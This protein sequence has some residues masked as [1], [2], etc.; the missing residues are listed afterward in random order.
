MADSPS[1]SSSSSPGT[2][3]DRGGASSASGGPAA[4]DRGTSADRAKPPVRRLVQL[5]LRPMLLIAALA[6]LFFARLVLHPSWVLYTDYSDLLTYQVP[7]MRFLVSSWQQTGEQPLWCPYSFA[8]MPFVHDLQVGAFYPFHLMLYRLPE[9]LIGPA[10]SW[11][12]VLHVMIA[13]WTM[14]A[15]ARSQGLNQTCAMIAA[16]GFMFSGKWLLHLVQ[17]AQYVVIGLAW[18]PLVLLLLERSLRGGGLRSATWAGAALA[19]VVLSSHPQITFY[20]GLLIAFWTLPLALEQAGLL[21]P[22][23]GRGPSSP[24]AVARWLLSVGWC[25]LVALALAAVQLLPTIEAGT[26]TTRSAVGMPAD[27]L[28]V[29]LFNIFG[30]VGPAP[31]SLPI[32]GWENRTGLTVIW[33]ATALLTPN[34]YSWAGPPAAP[35][36]GLAWPDRLRPWRIVL[37]S[38]ASR[39]PFVPAPLANVPRR[40]AASI[41]A[42]RDR[43]PGDVRPSSI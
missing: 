2:T 20:A 7:Q 10:L 6:F 31:E 11:L 18:L 35:G 19:L 40:C 37:L 8:G 17:A 29:L 34:L 13:G 30:L 26:Q 3:H 28:K 32:T 42:R 39:L 14:F 27:I 12:I 24:N 36:L 38:M 33:V 22:A 23:P 41:P 43:D 25:C 1:V 21:G 15:Y 5:E 16:L 4:V 9:A